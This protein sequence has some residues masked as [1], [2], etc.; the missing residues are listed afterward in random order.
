[1]F[2][3]FTLYLEDLSKYYCEGNASTW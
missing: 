2:L 3:K 1:M